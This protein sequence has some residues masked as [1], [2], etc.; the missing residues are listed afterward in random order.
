M[1]TLFIQAKSK[2]V[3]DKKNILQISKKLPKTIVI[4]YSIQFKEIA[5]EIKKILSKNHKIN[6]FIQVLGCSKPKISKSTNAILLIGSGKF[7]GVSLAYETKTPVFVFENGALQE[8][9]KKEVETLRKR[10]KG[11]Y[12]KFLN[13]KRAGL[14][15]STKPGQNKLKKA[16]ELKKKLKEKEIYLFLTNNINPLEFQNFGLDSWIN[17]ACPRLDLIDTSIINIDKLKL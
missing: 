7:H 6:S 2:V 12:M 16:I 3:I 9:T 4:A 15:I 13:S 1:K 11:A 14:L 17:T 5:N 8:I 10:Q